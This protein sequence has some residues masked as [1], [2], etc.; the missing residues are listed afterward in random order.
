M[1]VSLLGEFDTETLDFSPEGCFVNPQ[2]L[3]CGYP[4]PVV[5]SQGIDNKL[6]F[7][8][9]QC[10]RRGDLGLG[11]EE[12]VWKMLRID[13]T[14]PTKDKRVLYSVFQFPY[15]AREIVSHQDV[16]HLRGNPSDV[17]AAEAIE[18]G[19]EVID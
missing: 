12:V 6:G 10:Y 17:F 3:C 1:G 2:L 5:P 9:T 18:P 16:K 7:K 14:A 11:W 13:E 8:L 19:N 15:I 4:V